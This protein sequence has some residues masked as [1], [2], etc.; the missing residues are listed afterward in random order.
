MYQFPN[1]VTR[2]IR[3]S[4]SDIVWHTVCSFLLVL[5]LILLLCEI[6]H[7]AWLETDKHDMLLG[8]SISESLSILKYLL[9][10]LRLHVV[11]LVLARR[12]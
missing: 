3:R 6:D 9:T 1:K 4:V 8:V 2:I 12:K 11:L 10:H 5:Q 7:H